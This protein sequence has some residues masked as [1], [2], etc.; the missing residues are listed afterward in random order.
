[1]RKILH[2]HMRVTAAAVRVYYAERRILNAPLRSGFAKQAGKVNRHG[3]PRNTAP[4]TIYLYGLTFSCLWSD[5]IIFL[6]RPL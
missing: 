2:A 6:V 1:M 3:A 4:P 5:D